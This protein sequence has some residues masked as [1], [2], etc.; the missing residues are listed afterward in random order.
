MCRQG[1]DSE[2]VVQKL[3]VGNEVQLR[4]GVQNN[5]KIVKW[6]SLKWFLM[7]DDNNMQTISNVYTRQSK[8][9]CSTC[10]GATRNAKYCSRKVYNEQRAL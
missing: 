1:K 9:R 5:Q 6:S 2:G 4:K 7:S 10:I 3:G 8:K